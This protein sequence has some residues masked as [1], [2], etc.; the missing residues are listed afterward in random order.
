M[1]PYLEEPYVFHDFHQ[2]FAS[3]AKAQL[4]GQIR[5]KYI[6]RI[7][8]EVV[9]H[10]PSA[11][12]RRVVRPDVF[13]TGGDGG[14]G[15]TLVGSV[16]GTAV[17]EVAKPFLARFPVFLDEEKLPFIEIRD[18]AELRL[19]SVVELI[20]PTNKSDHRSAYLSKRRAYTASGVNVVEID[21]LRAGRRM[22]VE[23]E[24]ACDYLIVVSRAGE[25]PQVATYPFDLRDRFPIVPVP[26]LP[27]DPDARLDIR[28]ILDEAYDK[29]GYADYI[30]KR[31]PT[32]PLSPADQAWAD[33]LIA[34]PRS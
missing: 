8:L 17:G 12:E 3:I 19:V 21:L 28:P 22:P 23:P 14:G 4:V 31:P 33:A 13:V 25:Y 18:R 5:P 32:P 20:S 1:D 6:A 9:I 26:L 7:D 29:S 24:P 16:G 30:Y 27:E 34:P 15:G 11:D 2:M 10:E